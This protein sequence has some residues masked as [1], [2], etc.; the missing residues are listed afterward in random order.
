M[1]SLYKRLGWIGD[2]CQNLLNAFNCP[3]TKKKAELIRALFKEVI[4]GQYSCVLP[5]FFPE[6]PDRPNKPELIA[7]KHVPRPRISTGRTGRVALLHVIAKIE[8]NAIYLALEMTG[9]YATYGLH[10]DFVRD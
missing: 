9:Q 5:C 1:I 3:D 10:F 6:R 8:L 7:P 4:D 2:I